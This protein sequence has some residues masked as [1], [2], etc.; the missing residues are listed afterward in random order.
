MCYVTFDPWTIVSDLD[1][2]VQFLYHK[3]YT[4]KIH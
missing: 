2:I 3:K 1:K 4:L